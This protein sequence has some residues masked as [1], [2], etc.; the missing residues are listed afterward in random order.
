MPKKAPASKIEYREYLTI[1]LRESVVKPPK[2]RPQDADLPV[3]PEAGAIAQA[4][5]VIVSTAKGVWRTPI[6][7]ITS[8]ISKF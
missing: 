3:A 2:E 7:N 4:S 5:G 1:V 6:Y 8:A